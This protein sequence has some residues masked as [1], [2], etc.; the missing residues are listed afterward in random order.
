[1]KPTKL[2]IFYILSF[3]LLL[4]TI[5]IYFYMG[6]SELSFT[7]TF[8]KNNIMAI[9]TIILIFIITLN[10][11]LAYI[12]KRALLKKNLLK[13]NLI[14]LTILSIIS[15]ITRIREIIAGNFCIICSINTIIYLILTIIIILILKELYNLIKLITE[16][17]HNNQEYEIIHD[18]TPKYKKTTKIKTKTNH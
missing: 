4:N 9:L 14:I 2:I 7:L 17:K 6:F 11:I 15:I 1:M 13:I 10:T 8:I 5:Y 16:Q 3:I 12:I 18:D